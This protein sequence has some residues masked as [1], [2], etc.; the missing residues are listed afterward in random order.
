MKLTENAE[1]TLEAIF[2]LSKDKKVVRVKDIAKSLNS[3]NASV[4]T[5]LKSLSQK[6]L[7]QH[8]HY[9]YVELTE[10]G[11][12]IAR[13]LYKRHQLL[14]KFFRETLGLP[15]HIAE[16]DA[17]RIEHYLSEEGLNGIL[18]LI[19]FINQCPEGSP[20]WL[21]NFHYFLEYNK[22]PDRCMEK[23][24]KM[25]VLLD[26]ESAQQGMI[27]KLSGSTD[28]RQD[29]L[30]R[31]F[32]PGAIVKI[33]DKIDEILIVLVND[34]KIELPLSLSK[35]IFVSVTDPTLHN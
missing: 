5:C 10:K 19:E 31:G 15:S 2:L 14:Y 20:V 6:G 29:L 7:V 27:I 9:G 8:E 26:M 16:R 11:K 22:Y 4:V 28:I 34:K 30:K 33:V 18:K 17:C 25:R 32:V 35:N 23:R 12:A 21:T 13:D 1:D 24:E 3:N